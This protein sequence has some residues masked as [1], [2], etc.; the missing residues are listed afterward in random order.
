MPAATLAL[1]EAPYP[2]PACGKGFQ[3]QFALWGHRGR[4]AACRA[5]DVWG[6]LAPPSR[7]PSRRPPIPERLPRLA[8]QPAPQ[9]AS[10]LASQPASQPRRRVMT[11][12]DDTD[13]AGSV[14]SRR[15]P[16]IARRPAHSNMYALPGRELARWGRQL[17]ALPQ[18]RAEV[19]VLRTQLG[20]LARSAPGQANAAPAW[21][22]LGWVAVIGLVSFF[23]CGDDDADRPAWSGGARRRGSNLGGVVGTAGRLVALAKGLRSLGPL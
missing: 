3:T 16:G 8:T 9:P 6:E 11:G 23:L 4:V 20:S 1:V 14:G 12:F 13:E 10:R 18:L 5:A 15:A 17:E 21:G 2:C 22:W 19:R 7:L